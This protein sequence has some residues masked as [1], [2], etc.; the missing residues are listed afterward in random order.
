M[1]RFHF[2]L[3]AM[4]GFVAVVAVA[5]AALARPSQLWLV[6]VSASSLGCLFYAVLAAAY[7]R[8]A[9]RAFWLGYAAFAWGYVALQWANIPFFIPTGYVSG[10]LR[11]V[12]Y[13]AP[14]SSVQT[15]AGPYL[16]PQSVAYTA[17]EPT[18]TEGGTLLPGPTE[19]LQQ[20][21]NG[22]AVT[23]GG[24]PYTTSIYVTNP[25]QQSATVDVEAFGE[26]AKWLWSI[27][28]GFA[29]GLVARRL[30]HRRERQDGQTV[31]TG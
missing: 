12:L 24:S 19:N 6:V 1:H 18:V 17:G 21:A 13:P 7:G 23:P 3:L 31:A 27:L 26:I 14:T 20:W 11:S 25:V 30:Y 16:T 2:S 28:L 9:R 5:C 15:T 8:N 10:E 22:Y 29:G 4:F